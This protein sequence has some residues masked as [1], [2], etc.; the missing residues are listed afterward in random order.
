VNNNTFPFST[1]FLI[2][3]VVA[4]F[5]AST[6]WPLYRSIF[7]PPQLPNLEVPDNLNTLEGLLKGD[8]GIEAFKKF[9]TKEF[10]VENV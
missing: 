9:L 10:S 1:L 7:Q 6:M 4:A 3:A 8:L 5:A 2:I